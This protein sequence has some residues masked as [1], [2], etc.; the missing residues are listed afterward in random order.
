M[1]KAHLGA[2]FIAALG[3]TDWGISDPSESFFRNLLVGMF[4]IEPNRP[5]NNFAHLI[6]GAGEIKDLAKAA[7]ERYQ[8]EYSLVYMDIDD[9]LNDIPLRTKDPRRIEKKMHRE[10]D[11]TKR[12]PN[13]FLLNGR[14]FPLTLRDTP[15]RVKLNE[16]VKLRVLNAGARTL[17]LH[18]HGHHRSGSARRSGIADGAGR[19]SRLGSRGLARPRPHRARGDQ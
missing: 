14:S 9:R 6:P 10:Y 4:I 11:S 16:R 2:R 19:P 13:I 3:I 18:T 15:I 12:R 7:L 17:A 8:R 1:N 5:G